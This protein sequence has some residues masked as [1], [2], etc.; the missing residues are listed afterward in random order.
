MTAI[1]TDSTVL[2]PADVSGILSATQSLLSE[3]YV[4]PDVARQVVEVLRGKDARGGYAD[5]DTPRDLGAAVT[6]DLQSVNGD[7]HLRLLFHPDGVV[8]EAD[9]KAFMASYTMESERNGHGI[10][11]VRRLPG[12]VAYLELGPKLYHHQIAGDS[13]AAAMRLVANAR[14]LVLDLRGCVGGSPETVAMICSY[15]FEEETHLTDQLTNNPEDFQQ[16]WTMPWVPGPKL[17]QSAS[18]QVL[19]SAA[20]FSGGEDLAYTL[21][22]SGRATVVGEVTGGGAHPRRGFTVHSHLE[23]TI[24]VAYSRN[25]VSKTDWEGVGVQPDLVVPA[26]DAVTAALERAGDPS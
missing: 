12:N 9:E 19:T 11:Q 22:Q 10:L 26:A 14:S 25:S 13:I 16:R 17:P 6:T 20:T 18:L 8:D 5:C 3:H 15:L 1:S 2:S 7:R 4:F 21:Q 23:A 24:P